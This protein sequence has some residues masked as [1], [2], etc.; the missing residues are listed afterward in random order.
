VAVREGHD[1]APGADSLDLGD[2]R[3]A[4]SRHLRDAL[5]AGTA[6]G[7]EV[8]LRVPFHDLRAGEPFVVAVVEF[9][10]CIQRFRP[11]MGEG[12]LGSA[13]RSLEGAGVDHRITAFQQLLDQR[14][15]SQRLSNT[16]LGER[17][18][19]ATGVLPRD[20]PFGGAVTNKQDKRGQRR[21]MWHSTTG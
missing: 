2:D 20:R 6:G 11:S 18:I 1:G 3:I 19:S 17:Q 10:Q 7:E 15:G 16:F 4:P 9:H 14:S 13:C 21:R 12:Q 8:P 5:A